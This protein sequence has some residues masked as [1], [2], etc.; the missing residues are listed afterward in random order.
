MVSGRNGGTS[1][2]VTFGVGSRGM[3]IKPSGDL[4]SAGGSLQVRLRA[5]SE[6]RRDGQMP[7]TQQADGC[8]IPP[9]P[10][11]VGQESVRRGA[12]RLKCEMALEGSY[13]VKLP[14]TGNSLSSVKVPALIWVSVDAR[15]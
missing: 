7:T 15:G 4:T 10:Q 5:C 1:S 9:R 11:H 12:T 8:G 14:D 13:P 2:G 6:R 3:V